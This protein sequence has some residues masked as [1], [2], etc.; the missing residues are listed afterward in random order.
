MWVG[1]VA[2]V[3]LTWTWELKP[4]VA[5]GY[6]EVVVPNA[7]IATMHAA[8]THYGNVVLLDR[9]NVGVSQLNLPDGVCRDN[10]ADRVRLCNSP[11]SPQYFDHPIQAQ[12]LAS[13]HGSSLRFVTRGCI[14]HLRYV[15]P[16]QPLN[17]ELSEC[18]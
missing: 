15:L 12:V 9:T 2:V 10:P 8:V 7:G 5:Q 16:A 6:Y 18:L 11:P 14:Y 1:A 13:L 4:V 17:C 3:V